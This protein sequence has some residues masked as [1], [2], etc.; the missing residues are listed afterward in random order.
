MTPKSLS[1]NDTIGII[2]PS[3]PI[4]TR[5]GEFE[6][7]LE[8]LK[9][10][11]FKIKLSNNIEKHN[12]YSAGEPQERADDLNSL[13]RDKTVKAIVCATGGVTSNQI[14][15]LIDYDLIKNNPKIFIGYSDNT[16]LLLAINK[17][18]QLVTYHGPDICELSNQ[19]S[20]T[21][22]SYELFLKTGKIILDNN[23]ETIKAGKTK[24]TLLGGNLLALCG[25]LPSEFL[26]SFK[27]SVLFIEDVGQS[28]AK[29]DFYLNQLK[30]S[31]QLDN[32]SGLVIGHLEDCTDKKYPQDNKPIEKI[33]IDLCQ[34]YSFPIIK[35]D[36][37][38]HEI[39]NFKILPLGVEAE[40]NTETK[41]FVLA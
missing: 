37:F 6:A 34:K 18:T 19:N 3:R 21:Q 20:E 28:P 7:G 24:G 29:L 10:F 16:N 27:N 8:V 23:F 22:S 32:I 36:Y 31:G 4:Y 12:Y 5:E 14:L 35:V 2:A 30:L 33:L 39:R 15:D 26:P 1:N 40:I 41:T 38:G 11:G 17:R 13:F 25:L 9:K